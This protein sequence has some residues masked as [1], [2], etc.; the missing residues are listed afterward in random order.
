MDQL[1][2]SFKE[3]LEED[4]TPL[5][6]HVQKE[7]VGFMEGVCEGAEDLPDGAYFAALTNCTEQFL[8]EKRL[9]KIDAHGLV[10]SYL[11]ARSNI[12]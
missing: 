9:F 11:R 2:K 4:Q 6:F 1:L 7:Y 8:E 5:P 10:M 12:N 3:V